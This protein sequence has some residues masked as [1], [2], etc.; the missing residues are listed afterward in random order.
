M[1]SFIGQL[2]SSYKDLSVAQTRQKELS[3][4]VAKAGVEYNV[5]DMSSKDLGFT[6]NEEIKQYLS[7]KS[8]DFDKEVA[9]AE[10]ARKK[11]K[12]RLMMQNRKGINYESIFDSGQLK[13]RSVDI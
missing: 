3:E 10:E 5:K 12:E 13:K 1:I 4:I 6:S 2:D 8:G 7:V 11:K 9:F